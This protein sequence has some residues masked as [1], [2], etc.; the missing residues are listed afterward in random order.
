[1]A[2]MMACVLLT[3][4]GSSAPPRARR[5]AANHL[6]P[7]SMFRRFPSAMFRRFNARH[8]RLFGSAMLA[9]LSTAAQAEEMQRGGTMV[10]IVQPEP[11][12]L[13][14]YLSGAG[15]VCPVACQ[16]YEGLLSYDWDLKPV[17]KLAASWEISPD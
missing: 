13:A 6:E 12:T 3:R 11:A 15:N 17:P 16:V 2:S 10:M 4:R 14:S 9:V 7:S 5:S 8:H 1:M